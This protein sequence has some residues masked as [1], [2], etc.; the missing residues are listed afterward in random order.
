MTGSCA[1]AGVLITAWCAGCFYTAPIND[2]PSIDSVARVC[3]DS[4]C[5][6]GFADLH[7]GD[8]FQ[9]AATFHDPDGPASECRY[10]WSAV[11]C[12]A[13]E[14]MCDPIAGFDAG[15]ASPRIGV[16]NKVKATDEPV[17]IVL[18]RLE[19]FDGR[20][21]HATFPKLIAINEGPSLALRD[22]SRTHTVGGPIPVFATF[23][24]PD[25]AVANVI[26]A[27]SASKAGVP[28]PA[29]A[30]VDLAVA[31]DPDDPTHLTAGKIFVPP[32]VGD[33]DVAVSAAD[34]F[35][36]KTVQHLALHVV[37]DVPPCL[38]EV[39]PIVPPAGAVLPITAPTRFAVPLVTDDLD[40]YPAIGDPRFGPPTFRWSIRP[41]GA[42]AWQPLAG[43]VTSSFEL[44][45]G[46]F[47]LGDRIGVRVEVED[48]THAPVACDPAAPTCGTSACVQR[49]TWQVEA[50]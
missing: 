18:I 48:R 26:V 35:G 3:A 9:L 39:E 5:D 17:Q 13:H 50:R 40:P 28:A 22:A 4:P 37:A 44:D 31:P 8:T 14:T 45:P 46:A 42:A 49:Q 16:P 23:S 33:W 41:P 25:G 43:A 20:G 1:V 19:L 27:W 34:E 6:Q 29:G 10:N 15:V 21:A 36:Q 7:R 24:D 2:D 32:T 11:A 12:N 38:A 47:T 30:L